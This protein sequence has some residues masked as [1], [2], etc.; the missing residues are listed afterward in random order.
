MSKEDRKT[1]G[2]EASMKR[3]GT[4]EEAA[5]VAAVSLASC[6][7]SFTKGNTIVID[8]GTVLL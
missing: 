3:W 5:K 4:P 7:F 6:N 1:A 8:C 2:E